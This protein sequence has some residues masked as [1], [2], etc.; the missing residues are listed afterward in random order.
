MIYKEYQG[1]NQIVAIS[2]ID[3]N[4]Y[5]TEIAPKAFLSK[6]EICELTLPPHVT[7]IGQW[8]FA[9]MKNLRILTVP[10]NSIIWGKDVFLD[11]P[12]LNK[13]QVY[14]D[15]STNEGLPELMAACV[16]VLN[17]CDLVMPDIAGS[18]ENHKKWVSLF[19][20]AVMEF[21][22]SPDSAGFEP[23]LYGWFNDEGEED[24]KNSFVKLRREQ[25]VRL[26]FLRLRNDLYIEENIKNS[27]HKFIADHFL[28]GAKETEHTAVYDV[29]LKDLGRELVNIKI[30]Q[31]SGALNTNNREKLI[32]ALIGIGVNPEITAFLLLK[33]NDSSKD[34]AF[35]KL[36]L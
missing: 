27:L 14:P 10:A 34:N 18:F 35:D 7:K 8:G 5:Y 33:N 22:D 9:H 15:F 13:I 26:C 2:D 12:K 16:T 4:D 30:L 29:I 31:E 25:K 28:D 32:N 6:K 36:T 19:D 1:N 21:I 23:V 11:C 20:E 3:E 24:Q 17:R